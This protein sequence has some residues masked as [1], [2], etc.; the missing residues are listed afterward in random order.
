MT[1]EAPDGYAGDCVKCKTK[2]VNCCIECEQCHDCCRCRIFGQW[3]YPIAWDAER[4]LFITQ[5]HSDLTEFVESRTTKILK[6]LGHQGWLSEFDEYNVT[7]QW[8]GSCHCHPSYKEAKFPAEWIFAEDWE[9]RVDA[10]VMK[11][12]TAIA[13]RESREQ[14]LRERQ[15]RKDF[16][17]L[18][19]KFE[20]K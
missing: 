9:T 2:A 10:E 3:D 1:Q 13:I 16:E 17:R 5:K 8:N 14:Q 11:Q 15:E 12:K 18:R 6:R 7:Y 19:A 20:Q 4:F